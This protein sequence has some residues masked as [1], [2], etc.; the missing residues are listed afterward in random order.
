MKK[1]IPNMRIRTDI[2]VELYIIT[3]RLIAAEKVTEPA[4]AIYDYL[5][6]YS[7]QLA[8]FDFMET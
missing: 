2:I 8:L 5:A 1:T 6:A 7:N 4:Q 3:D